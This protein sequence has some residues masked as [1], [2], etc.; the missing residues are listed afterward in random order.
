MEIRPFGNTKNGRKIVAILLKN[1]NGMSVE[2]LNI[3]AAIRR[4]IVPAKDGQAV[5]VTLGYDTVDRYEVNYPMFGAVIGRYANRIRDAKYEL[6]GK[7]YELQPWKTPGMPML[8]SLPDTY[9][10]RA[11]NYKTVSEN[12]EESVTFYL[13]SPDMDQGYPGNADIAVTYTLTA[14][15]ELVLRYDADTDADTLVNLTNHAYFNLNG[16]DS[17]DVLDHELFIDSTVVP[18]YE[19]A[20]CPN[21]K[22]RNIEGT[23]FDFTAAKTIG[24]DLHAEEAGIQSEFGFDVAYLVNGGK[25]SEEASLVAELSSKKTG[26]AMEVYTDMPALQLYT[27]NRLNVR[28]AKGGASYRDYAGCCLETG[29][30]ANGINTELPEKA[31]LKAGEHFTSI[32]VYRFKTSKD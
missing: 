23:P 9:A 5:D 22:F 20:L 31:I 29:F 3:G 11:W 16:H 4:L 10:F 12:G 17:G 18:E 7:T 6:N 27:A 28:D 2:L 21:G 1:E 25:T 32:T 15:N 24:R 19:G 13:H 8:H 26:I 30:V 14:D